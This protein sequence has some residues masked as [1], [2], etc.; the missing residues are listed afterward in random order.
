VVL[1]PDLAD[2]YG[3]PSRG[4]RPVVVVLIAVL[5]VAA[6]AWLAWVLVFQAR[7]QV[8]SQLVGYHVRGE[9]ATSV[10]FTVVLRGPDVRAS[11][12]VQAVAADHAVVGELTVPVTS[13]PAT[14]RVTAT[15]RTERR[16]TGADVVGCTAVHR[17]R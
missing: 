9:H 10:T 16:A 17:R 14:R 2:R 6:A 1:S 12:L 4:R 5:V 13:G 7:P 3:V 11:C 8:S 15:V